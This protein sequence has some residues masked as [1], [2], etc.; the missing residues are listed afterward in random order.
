MKTKINTV[1]NS[2]SLFQKAASQLR[3]PEAEIVNQ[4]TSY[5]LKKFLENEKTLLQDKLKSNPEIKKFADQKM[6]FINAE[7]TKLAPTPDI[8]YFPSNNFAVLSIPLEKI[9][10]NDDE[11]QIK[12]KHTDGKRYFIV[13]LE[14]MLKELPNDGSDFCGVWRRVLNERFI[15]NGPFWGNL[16]VGAIEVSSDTGSEYLNIDKDSNF[17]EETDYKFFRYF[18]SIPDTAAH[19]SRHF[20]QYF[21]T[22]LNNYINTGKFHGEE[23]SGRPR[24]PIKG[25]VDNQQEYLLRDVE[26]Y[27]WLSDEILNFKRVIKYVP[28]ELRK[29]FF[30]I[31]TE[32]AF[33]FIRDN[34][35]SEDLKQFS[36]WIEK[37]KAPQYNHVQAVIKRN[38]S[39]DL[40]VELKEEQPSK[41]KKLVKEFFKEVSSYL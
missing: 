29:T 24:K 19:E 17:S 7:L 6:A 37:L 15:Q 13:A 2:A 32:G 25:V 38:L 35:N 5:F 10:Y 21:I 40:F 30:K 33:Y 31:Y 23:L 26:F 20:M 28:Q 1:Y 22:A 36:E 4:I 16:L 27:P 14:I 34:R 12:V 3:T 9:P 11:V 18:N 8:S 41:W 39:R